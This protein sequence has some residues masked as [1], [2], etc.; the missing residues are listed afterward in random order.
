MK[1]RGVLSTLTNG[2][3]HILGITKEDTQDTLQHNMLDPDNGKDY[4]QDITLGTLIRTTMLS[5]QGQ[6]S[7]KAYTHL[8]MKELT[9]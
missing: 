5:I 3:K 7:L 1:A 8:T 4:S 6:D 2:Q 9:H